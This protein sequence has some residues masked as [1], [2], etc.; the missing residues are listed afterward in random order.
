MGTGGYGVLRLGRQRLEDAAQVAERIGKGEMAEQLRE[1]AEKMPEVH[2]PEAAAELA[3][4][5]R[6]VKERAWRLG[7]ACGLAHR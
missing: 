5:M 7:R 2:T 6:P 4:E 3:E 1:I